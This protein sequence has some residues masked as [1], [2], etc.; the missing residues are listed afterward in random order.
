VYFCK[1]LGSLDVRR[2][3]RDMPLASVDWAR[4]ECR[5]SAEGRIRIVGRQLKNRRAR[6]MTGDFVTRRS[7]S[8]EVLT[9]AEQ[10]YLSDILWWGQLEP[11]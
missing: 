5:W 1:R 10:L 11:L 2:S 7:C 3:R 9:L 6:D 8:S 4:T